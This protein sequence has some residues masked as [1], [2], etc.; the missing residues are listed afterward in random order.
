MARIIEFKKARR[1]VIGIF[2]IAGGY[3]VYKE[4]GPYAHDLIYIQHE[5]ELLLERL[6]NQ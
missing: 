3:K 5:A 6:A 1:F 2:P 4:Y